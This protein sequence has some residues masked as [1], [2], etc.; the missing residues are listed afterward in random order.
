MLQVCL[1][2]TYSKETNIDRDNQLQKSY[3]RI[4]TFSDFNSHN[5]GF[6]TKLKLLKVK[7][8]FTLDKLAFVFD[9]TEGY[10]REELRRLLTFEYTI[11][12][13]NA[14]F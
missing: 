5:N 10:I 8:V 3:I 2:W 9:Y 7:Y 14:F 13:R 12:F 4:Q 1:A 11:H 6:F